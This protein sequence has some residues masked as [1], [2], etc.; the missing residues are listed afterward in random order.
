MTS[1]HCTVKVKKISGK[2]VKAWPI[3][4]NSWYLHWKN[5]V[6]KILAL[7]YELGLYKVLPCARQP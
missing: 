1:P 4:Q 2:R 6:S 3:Y 7:N 5:K